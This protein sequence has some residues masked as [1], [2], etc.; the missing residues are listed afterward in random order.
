MKEEAVLKFN[1][2]GTNLNFLMDQ[3][4]YKRKIDGK[5]SSYCESDGS[6]AGLF[7]LGHEKQ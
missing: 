3:D 5:C 1:L 2:G 4:I 7:L 6:W